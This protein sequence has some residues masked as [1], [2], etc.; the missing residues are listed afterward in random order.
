MG[1]VDLKVADNEHLHRYEG[2]VDGE[3][4]G[5]ISYRTR[6]DGV[7]ILVHT[8]VDPAFE[9]KGVGSLLV[10][11]ALDAERVRGGK[12]VPSCPF[13]GAYVKRHPDYDDLLA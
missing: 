11:G 13:V 5:F 4:A 9:G 7:R 6:P 12:I 3:V 10:R 2:L 8:E 1:I